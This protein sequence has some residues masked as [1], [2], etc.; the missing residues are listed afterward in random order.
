MDNIE[1][2]ENYTCSRIHSL[3]N[4]LVHKLIE[5]EGYTDE[6]ARRFVISMAKKAVNEHIRAAKNIINQQKQTMSLIED[7]LNNIL[8]EIWE[9]AEKLPNRAENERSE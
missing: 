7:N 5:D 8:L 2:I 4:W 3:L 9:T 1:D 6:Q